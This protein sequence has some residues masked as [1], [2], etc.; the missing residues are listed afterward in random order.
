MIFIISGVLFI[1]SMQKSTLACQGFTVL[2]NNFSVTSKMW[3]WGCF[4]FGKISLSFINFKIQYSFIY[5]S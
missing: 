5:P 1:I 3:F 4:K 2:S